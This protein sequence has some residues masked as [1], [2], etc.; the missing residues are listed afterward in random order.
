MISINRD[1]LLTTFSPKTPSIYH[2]HVQSVINMFK[3]VSL[4]IEE[5]PK[6]KKSFIGKREFTINRGEH[7]KGEQENCANLLIRGA[8]KLNIDMV[9]K[10]PCYQS[11]KNGDCTDY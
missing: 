4:K 6:K 1:Q 5:I 10:N 2:E 7:C 3:F 8:S 9:F 11:Y